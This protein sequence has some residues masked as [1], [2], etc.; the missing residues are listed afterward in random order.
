MIQQ[1]YFSVY[2]WGKWNHYLEETPVHLHIHCSII[3]NSQGM[4]KMS[5]YQWMN[6]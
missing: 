4:E 6:G 1:F 2:I 5:A 3:Y